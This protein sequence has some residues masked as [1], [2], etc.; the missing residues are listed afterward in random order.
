MNTAKNETRLAFNPVVYRVLPI[1]QWDFLALKGSLQERDRKLRLKLLHTDDGEDFIVA[2]IDGFMD[3]YAFIK[4]AEE[5]GKKPCWLVHHTD[6]GP[7][8]EFGAT[9]EVVAFLA[10]G[11]GSC[12]RRDFARGSSGDGV[13]IG[14]V[15][16]RPKPKQGR[17]GG[18]RNLRDDAFAPEAVIRH[19]NRCDTNGGRRKTRGD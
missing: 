16:P 19:W 3:P 9:S 11:D 1:S 15:M 17:R 12:C 7:L 6:D 13:I 2:I 10:S 4:H 14:G 18:D 5:D 8:F